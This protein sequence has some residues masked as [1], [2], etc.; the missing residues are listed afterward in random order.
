[1]QR[2]KTSL[3]SVEIQLSQR[4]PRKYSGGTWKRKFGSLSWEPLAMKGP[5]GV[6]S[7][8][9]F[10]V[11]ATV[12]HLEPKLVRQQAVRARLLRPAARL[13]GSECDA[14]TE[15]GPRVLTAPSTT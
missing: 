15:S 14:I 11:R 7:L 10:P 3:H 4:R 8:E 2:K 6:I 5:R 12:D 9:S 1:M 13:L